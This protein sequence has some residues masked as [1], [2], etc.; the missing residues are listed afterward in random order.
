MTV[1]LLPF[2]LPARFRP[3]NAYVLR[4]DGPANWLDDYSFTATLGDEALAVTEDGDELVITISDTIT[5]ALESPEWST[6]RLTEAD[7]GV[8]GTGRWEP[9]QAG[10]LSPST[11]V[12]ITLGTLEV[13]VTLVLGPAGA[14]G[15]GGAIRVEDEGTSVVAAATGINFAGAGVTVTDAGSNEALVTIPGGGGGGISD[16]DKGDITVS[17]SGATWTIDNGAVTAAKVAAD[18]ATQAELD[19]EAALAR[20]ADNLTSGT[21]ADARIAATIA[22]DSEVSAGDAASVATAAAD[23][24]T[25]AM[26]AQAASEATAAA[27]ATTKVAA[28]AALARNADNLTSG[29]VADA[30][31]AATIAR[32]SE[33]TAAVAAEATLARNA[34]NITGGTVAD[35]RIASTIARDSEVAAAI[36]AL[37]QPEASADILPDL[38]THS[39]FLQLTLA[40]T[41]TGADAIQLAG[42]MILASAKM[43]TTGALAACTYANGTVGVGATLTADANGALGAIDTITTAAGDFIL[44]KNQATAYENGLYEVTTLGTAGTPFVLTRAAHADH[45]TDYANG[46]AVMVARGR[47]NKRRLL[48]AQDTVTMGTTAITFRAPA[49]AEATPSD[50]FLS[51]QRGEKRY[52]TDCEEL[53]TAVPIN[54]A[55]RMIGTPFSLQ[56]S[57]AASGVSQVGSADST[58]GALQFDTGTTTAGRAIIRAGGFTH[59][60]TATDRV[61]VGARLKTATVSDGTDTFTIRV[62]FVTASLFTAGTAPAN[63]LYFEA[64]ADGS[65]WDCIAMASSTPTTTDSG[66]AVSTS[67]QQLAIW[68]DEIAGSAYFYI[69]EAL[70]ATISSGFPSAAV[71]AGLAIVKSAGTTARTCNL[72]ILS[73]S[74]RDSRSN[75]SYMP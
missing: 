63:G 26:A 42:A 4:L 61:R 69:N 12:E 57:G 53:E 21:V 36:A 40:P 65:N 75:M 1:D 45:A 31:I 74:H 33:V 67:Y 8:V 50:V 47:V 43:A 66:V 62:G 14:G 49:R 25:K 11:E 13:A 73:V 23:A 2:D 41:P 30:R 70:V 24:T 7:A 55:Q 46:V 20:N 44:V 17:G 28:E 56:T 68:Y 5:T 60:F 32:D 27:D 71:A 9:S 38:A 3:G 16:G 15:G 34:D 22:R 51:A 58:Y 10:T 39:G 29:T 6:F 48:I 52:W 72:D 19:A 37:P 54:T 18:V 35:A 64:P 59:T